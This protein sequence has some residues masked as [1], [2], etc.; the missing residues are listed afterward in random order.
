MVSSFREIELSLQKGKIIY[1]GEKIIERD[2]A[3]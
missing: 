3:W 2:L 1:L